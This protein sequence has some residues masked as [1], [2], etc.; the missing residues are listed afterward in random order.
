MVVSLDGRSFGNIDVI[1]CMCR[2]R[3][4]TSGPKCYSTVTKTFDAKWLHAFYWIVAVCLHYTSSA[5]LNR[6]K[7]LLRPFPS[8]PCCAARVQCVKV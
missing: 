7:W 4:K 8:K 5:G 6:T 1:E 2:Y 3:K